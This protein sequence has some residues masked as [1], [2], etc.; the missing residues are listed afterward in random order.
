MPVISNSKSFIP[1]TLKVVSPLGK[2]LIYFSPLEFVTQKNY[3]SETSKFKLYSFRG[4]Q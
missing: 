2:S 1:Q 4:F 3:D